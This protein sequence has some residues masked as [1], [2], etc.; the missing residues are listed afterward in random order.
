VGRAGEIHVFI[1]HLNGTL[2][3]NLL[4]ERSMEAA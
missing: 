3:E 2:A 1:E 4:L